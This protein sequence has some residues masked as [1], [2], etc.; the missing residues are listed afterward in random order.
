MCN[1]CILLPL[2]LETASKIVC[3][4]YLVKNVLNDHKLTPYSISCQ[5]KSILITP[6]DVEI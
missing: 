3:I 5:S 4:N 2:A 1:Y 6:I